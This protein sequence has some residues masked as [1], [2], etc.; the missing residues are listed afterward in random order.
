[1]EI[2]EPTVVRGGRRGDD[3]RQ[4]RASRKVCLN[5]FTVHFVRCVRSEKDRIS[6]SACQLHGLRTTRGRRP[7]YH[8]A[9]L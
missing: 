4:G 3:R 6:S 8:L 9:V 2:K 5:T 1:M 7:P